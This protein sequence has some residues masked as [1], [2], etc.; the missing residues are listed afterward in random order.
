MALLLVVTSCVPERS[1]VSS[2]C[3]C[4]AAM[5]LGLSLS[6]TQCQQAKRWRKLKGSIHT[7]GL[8]LLQSGQVRLMHVVLCAQLISAM[9]GSNKSY[10]CNA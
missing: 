1:D 9:L 2:A 4:A 6:F 3:F 7:C 5:Y 10:Q 8:H